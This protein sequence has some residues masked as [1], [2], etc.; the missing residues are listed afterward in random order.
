MKEGITEFFRDA[1][2]YFQQ[3]LPGF[4]RKKLLKSKKNLL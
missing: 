2:F 1:F 3:I 4:N